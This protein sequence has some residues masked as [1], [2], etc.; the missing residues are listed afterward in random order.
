L[1][2]VGTDVADHSDYRKRAQVAI[3]I[4]E[5]D[6][7]A[8]RLSVRPLFTGQRLADQGHMRRVR[9]VAFV[10]ETPAQQRYT[11]RR[12]ETFADHRVRG[13]ARVERVVIQRFKLIHGGRALAWGQDDVAPIGIIAAFKQWQPADAAGVAY[14]RDRPQSGK[15][16]AQ[17][18]NPTSFLFRFF[19]R[20]ESEIHGQNAFRPKARIDRKDLEEAATDQSRTGQKHQRNGKLAD[21]NQAGR[22][23]ARQGRKMRAADFRQSGSTAPNGPPGVEDSEPDSNHGGSRQGNCE[24]RRTYGNSTDGLKLWR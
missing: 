2:R 19:N 13:I 16:L 5:L 14:T 1:Q 7:S 20:R 8:Q 23:V 11:E 10:K 21:D 12:K 24:R 9:M 18:S 3:H 15:Q 22:A 4:A 17:K 6:C